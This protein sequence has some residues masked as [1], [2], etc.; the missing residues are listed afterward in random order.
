P[1]SIEHSSYTR[2]ATRGAT[3][4]GFDELAEGM[5]VLADSFSGG[6]GPRYAFLYWDMIDRTGHFH[7][8]SSK[9]FRDASRAALDAVWEGIAHLRDVTVLITADHGQVDVRPDRVDYLDD[10]WTELPALLSQA[11]PAGSSRDVFLHVR[12]GLVDTVINGLATRLGD[13]GDV[14]PAAELFDHPGLRLT[15]RLGDVAVLPSPGRQAWLHQA[16]ANEQWFLGQHGGLHI[17]ESA[18]YLAQFIL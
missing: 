18:T 12:D 6:D 17:D 9:E 4:Q 1:R 13:R 8:P 10:L 15:Q 5:R 7:G 14:R 16:A 11:R 2:M 3:V